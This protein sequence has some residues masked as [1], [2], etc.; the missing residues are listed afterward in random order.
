MPRV[1]AIFIPGGDPGNHAPAALLSIAHA[2]LDVLR[3]SHPV[4][5]VWIGPQEWN[6]TVLAEWFALIADP[7]VCG[8]LG[9]VVYGP[10]TT[11]DLPAF[12][13]ATPPCFPVRLYPDICHSTTA[14]LPVWAWDPALAATLHREAINPRPT[15]HGTIAARMLPGT[16]G[17]SGYDEGVNDDVNKVVWAAVAWGDGGG[18]RG[19]PGGA[20]VVRAALTQYARL[21][22]GGGGSAGNASAAADVLYALE[23]N[24]VGPLLPNAGVSVALKTAQ[25][26]LEQTTQLNQRRGTAG[27]ACGAWRIHQV[28]Y[29]AYYDVFVQGRLGEHKRA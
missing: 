27:G 12:I 23:S 6:A 21:F 13:N 25:A 8:W 22:L 3:E 5:S 28:L 2:Q 1:D 4:A 9:G 19:T 18:S 11:M 14:Q 7:A 24:W 29:R 20:A 26:L 17:F 15:Q 10:W 16:V